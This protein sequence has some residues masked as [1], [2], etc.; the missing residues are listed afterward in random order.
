MNLI[1]RISLYYILFAIPALVICAFVCYHLVYSQVKEDNDENMMIQL[2][3]IEAQLQKTDTTLGILSVLDSNVS[4]KYADEKRDTGKAFDM[5]DYVPTFSDTEMYNRDEGE[6]L[7]Y[8]VLRSPFSSAKHSYVI[9]IRRTYLES[10]D[11]IESILLTVVILFVCLLAGFFL[12]NILI[13]KRSWKPFYRTLEILN[14]YELDKAASFQ[15]PNTRTKEFTQ[16]NNVLNKM[17]EQVYKDFISQ[18]QFSENASHEMQTPLAVIKNKIELLIQSKNI[19][20]ADME[21]IQSIYNSA[22]KL[23]QINRALL[24]LSKIESNQF[25]EVKELQL[26]SLRSK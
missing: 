20:A 19:S 10:D 8:R 4:V 5:S 13:A 9:T 18:K 2:K 14:E 3:K 12:I 11:L 6:M 25:A 26:S 22:N 15:F 24:L 16:L 1:N 17:T 23:S 7:P 21:I